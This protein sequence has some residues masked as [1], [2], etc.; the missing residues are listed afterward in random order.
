VM[1][2]LCAMDGDCAVVGDGLFG[3]NKELWT[4]DVPS[5]QPTLRRGGGGVP[6]TAHVCLFTMADCM[7][8]VQKESS[9]MD[10]CGQ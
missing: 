9:Q 4:V 6:C 8:V 2:L 1:L 5:H 10:H 3:L 7:R